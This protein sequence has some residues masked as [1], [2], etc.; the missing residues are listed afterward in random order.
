MN[1]LN[2][3]NLAKNI[4]LIFYRKILLKDNL[5]LILDYFFINTVRIIIFVYSTS[6]KKLIFL[7]PALT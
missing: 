3:I 1:L 2:N 7:F 4:D 5:L 6:S